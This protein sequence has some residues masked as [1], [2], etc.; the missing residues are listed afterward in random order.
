MIIQAIDVKLEFF[1]LTGCEPPQFGGIGD[2]S[3]PPIIFIGYTLLHDF[4]TLPFLTKREREYFDESQSTHQSSDHMNCPISD[5][6]NRTNFNV[7]L[8]T[9]RATRVVS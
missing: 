8:T 3:A 5:I 1:T 9:G 7:F 6:L 2:Q 4:S